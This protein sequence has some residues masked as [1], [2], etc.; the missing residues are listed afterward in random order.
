VTGPG[1]PPPRA[2]RSDERMALPPRPK[3]QTPLRAAAEPP[4][5]PP[6]EVELE[7]APLDAVTSSR[8][9]DVIAKAVAAELG[10]GV[11]LSS[12][13]PPSEPPRSSMRVAADAGRAAAVKVGKV[14]VPGLIGVGASTLI[15]GLIALWRPEYA[16]PVLKLLAALIAAYNG[17]PAPEVGP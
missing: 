9:A 6:V 14:G 4:S 16:V 10:K 15:A 5:E 11:R 2:G 1:K 12:A 8:L 17:L 3:N 13:P 7:P